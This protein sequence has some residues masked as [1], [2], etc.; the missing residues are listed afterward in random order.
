VDGAAGL[1]L[2]PKLTLEAAAGSADVDLS[3]SNGQV[4]W[5][6]DA[7]VRW[8][9]LDG[10]GP[11]REWRPPD[12]SPAL[13]EKY[14]LLNQRPALVRRRAELEGD[15]VVW[16]EIPL[17]GGPAVERRFSLGLPGFSVKAAPRER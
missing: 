14:R 5:G 16:V 1:V 9:R 17:D 12:G 4:A 8:R 10:T 6:G 2:E 3:E 7:W 15:Q 13:A 11:I